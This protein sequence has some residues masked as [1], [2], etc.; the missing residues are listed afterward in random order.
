MLQLSDLQFRPVICYT[1]CTSKL[2]SRNRH[3]SRWEDFMLFNYVGRTKTGVSTRYGRECKLCR[4]TF[5]SIIN[6]HT[7]KYDNANI[8][9]E[10]SITYII[11]ILSDV[12]VGVGKI[13]TFRLLC[14]LTFSMCL[15]IQLTFKKLRTEKFM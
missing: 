1:T 9:N 4:T 8:H 15:A 5:V 10:A 2:L 13:I 11:Y 6:S 3:P 14:K 7:L 12:F